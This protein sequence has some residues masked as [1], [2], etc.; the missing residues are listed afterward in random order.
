MRD[1]DI[2]RRD[3]ASRYRSINLGGNMVRCQS[4]RV[5]GLNFEVICILDCFLTSRKDSV[6]SGKQALQC[7][8]WVSAARAAFG[9]ERRQ[10]VTIN[11]VQLSIYL[12]M[13][14][15][16][17]MSKFFIRNADCFHAS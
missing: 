14:M 5:G 9:Q 1:D 12:P 6:D 15:G 16:F 10:R 2:A 3:E 17:R 7:P 13:T 8:C 11:V 4:A